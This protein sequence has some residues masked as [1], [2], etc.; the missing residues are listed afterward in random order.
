MGDPMHVGL[1]KVI[2]LRELQTFNQR[3]LFSRFRILG[4][5]KFQHGND[6]T[7]PA[8]LCFHFITPRT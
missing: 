2:V 4:H 8:L 7:S 3:L 1:S 5:I 6:G